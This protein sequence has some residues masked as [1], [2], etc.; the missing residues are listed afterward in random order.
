MPRAL[1]DDYWHLVPA[2]HILMIFLT[3]V[4]SV[5]TARGGSLDKTIIL[6]AFL[7]KHILLTGCVKP[8]LHNISRCLQSG[9][10]SM[11]LISLLFLSRMHAVA[12]SDDTYQSQVTSHQSPHPSLIG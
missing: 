7:I 3:Q 5:L 6:L 10:G 8:T 4:R 12:G 9:D 11:I 1:S 2:P